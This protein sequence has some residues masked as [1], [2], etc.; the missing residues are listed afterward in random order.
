MK[1][2]RIKTNYFSRDRWI[3][4][5][6]LVIILLV[7]GRLV[8][9]QVVQAS[10]LKAK[11]I[12]R[13]TIDQSLRPDR[14]AIFDAQGNVLAQSIPVKEVYADPRMLSKQIENKKFERSKEDVAKE[15][16]SILEIDPQAILDKLNKDLAWISLAHQVDIQKADKIKA[17]KIPGVGYSE[18]EKRVYPMGMFA[19][20]ALG[21]VNG[22]GH[23]VEGVEYY[24]DK[25]LFGKPGFQSEEQDTKARSILDALNQ[26]DPSRPGNSI[27]LTLDATIQY[28]IEQQLDQAMKAT[29]ANSVT[30]LAMDPMTGRVLGM[31]SR[32]SFDPTD[33][34]N[35][36]PEV[37]RN[38]AISMSYEP[39]STFKIIT[40]A[41]ALEEGKIQPDDTFE[42]PGFLRISPLYITN[43][44]SD[45]KPHG[46]PTFTEGMQLSS[47]VVLAQ[48]GLKMGKAIFDTYLK[49][50]GFGS[51]TSIDI[52]GE[53]SG[54]LLPEEKIREIDIA[55][56]SFGQA[57][58]VT[59]IQLLT[60]IS[61][62]ANGGTLYRPY[63]VDKISTFDGQIVEQKQPTS[64][65]QVVSQSTASQMTNILEQ[66]VSN[67]TG[68]TASIPG[69]RVAGKTGTAQKVD[70]KTGGYSTTDF[71]ASFV[72][73]A[74]AEDPKIAVL[75][76]IDTPKTEE[77]HQGGTLAG[78][79]AKAII[80]GA[81]QY[82]GLPVSNDTQSTVVISPSDT[83][84]RPL[85]Q[86]VIPERT[87]IGGEIVIPDLTGM[88]MRQ[89]GE[90]LA[91]SELHFDFS[92]S[93]LVNQQSPQA[94][95]IVTRGATVEV[96]FSPLTP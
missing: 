24:Y 47:N 18:E 76:I 3:Q 88:T 94:G 90:T 81:L 16:G 64:V 2:G 17:L 70:P 79:R 44:D 32:P 67:G 73:Y 41:A 14:G 26:G 62:I 22:D 56:M 63:I 42:D 27:T 37:R 61:A 91:K 12:E 83:A 65:R 11:G 58:S 85:P 71:I 25:E 4:L 84:V 92:G 82:Y 31:G 20:S 96:K 66:V 49:A 86:P 95:K 52:S 1:K 68:N 39:G 6:L 28:Y 21:I 50:F 38:L 45:Q 69:I 34:N 46:Y 78:P 23:G 75:V 40:G 89:A 74:P 51:K 59:P 19:A 5:I 13:R 87:P 35:V 9:L 15:L 60:A 93:G 53:E 54:L 72:A 29:K 36:T 48:V 8:V 80:E 7:C 57:N 55:T 30:I 33:Y 10:N 43:W 77:G